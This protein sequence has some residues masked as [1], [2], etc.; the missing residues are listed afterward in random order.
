MSKAKK[1]I[2]ILFRRLRNA[3]GTKSLGWYGT[4]DPPLPIP[5]REVK[6]CRADGTGV[7]PGRVGRRPLLY[8]PFRNCGRAFSFLCRFQSV[9]D[10]PTYDCRTCALPRMGTDRKGSGYIFWERIL[11]SSYEWILHTVK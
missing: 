6:P 10:L 5:N 11:T 3:G 9:G 4:G 7:T 8:R 1:E 2:R